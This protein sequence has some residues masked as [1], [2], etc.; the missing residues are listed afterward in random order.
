MISSLH[1]YYDDHVLY[2]GE[3][4]SFSSLAWI[5][6][7]L[8]NSM[9]QK[10]AKDMRIFMVNPDTTGPMIKVTMLKQKTDVKHG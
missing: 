6:V 7:D 2:Y 3:Y 5:V 1:I 4:F 8:E 9:R 10:K